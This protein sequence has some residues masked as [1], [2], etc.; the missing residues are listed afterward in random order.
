MVVMFGP[1]L[2]TGLVF[3]F[4]YVAA[5]EWGVKVGLS[6]DPRSRLT[7]FYQKHNPSKMRD[8]DKLLRQY[9]GKY[10]ELFRKLEAKYAR[11]DPR[12]QKQAEEEEEFLKE[13]ARYE[14][15]AREAQEKF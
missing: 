6:E 12:K 4:D 3:V 8:V 13:Q 15:E 10:A 11:P 5:S 2:L 9:E 14:Q 1:V 7:K